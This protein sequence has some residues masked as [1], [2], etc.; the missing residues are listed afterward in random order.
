M[1]KKP[2]GL[3]TS[4][5]DEKAEILLSH[6]RNLMGTPLPHSW[7]LNWNALNL[8]SKDLSH[9]DSDFSMEELKEVIGTLHSEK[10]TGPDGFIGIFYKK[11]WD[12]VSKDLLM[13]INQLHSLKADRWNV[14]NSTNIALIPKKVGP[15]DALEFR[16]IS[17]MH[18]I[19]QILCKLLANR[20]APELQHLVSH[21]QSAFTKKEMHT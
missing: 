11:C 4:D 10:A 3:K 19:A 14:L 1:L 8:P 6:F 20:L 7:Q 12:I 18:R 9:L 17:L 5:H 13:A 16:P 15:C 2:D 21:S